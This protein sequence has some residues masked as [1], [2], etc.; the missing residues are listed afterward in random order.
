M[1]H[2]QAGRPNC[3]SPKQA[4]TQPS[5]GLYGLISSP[6]RRHSPT[7]YLYWLAVSSPGA[8]VSPSTGHLLAAASDPKSPFA[9]PGAC[10]L[11]PAHPGRG[12][13]AREHVPHANCLHPADLGSPQQ[14]MAVCLPVP[15]AP[16]RLHGPCK[17]AHPNFLTSILHFCTPKSRLAARQVGL[18]HPVCIKRSAC[19][20]FRFAPI[21]LQLTFCCCSNLPAPRPACPRPYTPCRG[22]LRPASSRSFPM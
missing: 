7:G 12:H 2:C 18:T 5:P 21:K 10:Q 20:S 19:S 4:C 16:D 15:A 17:Q 22:C 8:H 9:R 11:A 1:A 6:P 3:R 14:F 13:A